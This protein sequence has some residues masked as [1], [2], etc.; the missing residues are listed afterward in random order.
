MTKHAVSVIK[1]FL[2]CAFTTFLW[3]STE[4]S[5]AKSY[6]AFCFYWL[7]ER[8]TSHCL[9]F[10][11]VVIKKNL[12]II[13]CW[14]CTS[15]LKENIKWVK[16]HV[17]CLMKLVKILELFRTWKAVYLSYCISV[18][19]E[20]ESEISPFILHLP[21][22]GLQCIFFTGQCANLFQSIA[23]VNMNSITFCSVVLHLIPYFY[24]IL[25]L[26]ISKIRKSC[27]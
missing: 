26:L 4:I 5:V 18:L 24:W 17:G 12:N 10:N 20:S 8:W 16:Q 13:N 2:N 7:N 6:L 19:I 11:D 27:L 21:H 3:E 9:D 23:K 25:D 22:V 15:I 14:H 1:I